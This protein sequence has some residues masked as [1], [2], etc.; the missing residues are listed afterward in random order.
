[1]DDLGTGNFHWVKLWEVEAEE[2]E[3]EEEGGRGC[4]GGGSG[5]VGGVGGWSGVDNGLGVVGL[6]SDWVQWRKKP[7]EKSGRGGVLSFRWWFFIVAKQS[8][9]YNKRRSFSYVVSYVSV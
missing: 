4:V 3:E 2:K 6:R 7:Q 9:I 8:E 5:T 1:M